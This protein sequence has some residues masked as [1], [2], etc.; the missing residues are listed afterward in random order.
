M[1]HTV[2]HLIEH[3]ANLLMMLIK[4]TECQLIHSQKKKPKK[5][6]SLKPHHHQPNKDG[7]LKL[8]PAGNQEMQ[9][10]ATHRDAM[11]TVSLLIEHA[12]N[13]L[14]MSKTVTKCQLI[15]SHN[16]KKRRRSEWQ[17]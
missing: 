14:M 5:D 1:E 6:H 9:L 11:H 17:V 8:T 2:L 13:Q 7:T 10:N 12:A 4:Q 16:L 15:H 3:A